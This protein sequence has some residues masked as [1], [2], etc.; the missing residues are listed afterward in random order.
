MAPATPCG[1]STLAKG[2]RQAGLGGLPP[3]RVAG[4]VG[5]EVCPGGFKFVADEAQ[6]E[7]PAPEGVLRVVRDRAGGACGL[8]VQGLGAYREAQLDVGLD[9]PGV[10]CAVEGAELDGVRRALRGEGGVEVEQVVAAVVVVVQGAHSPVSAAAATV[11]VPNLREAV[12]GGGLGLVDRLEESGRNRLAPLGPAFRGDAQGLC[13]EVF[14][15]IDQVD[16]PPQALR[17]VCPEADVDVDAAGAVNLGPGVPEVPDHRLHH[18]DVLPAAHRADHLRAGVGHRGIAF[19]RPMPPVRHRHLPVVEVGSDVPGGRS[20]EGRDGLGC[21]SAP[22]T[23]CFNLDAESLVFH[24]GSFARR[25][26]PPAA[27]G[28]LAPRRDT[29]ITLFAPNSNPTESTMFSPQIS[30]YYT[31]NGRRKNGFLN[32]ARTRTPSGIG[33]QSFWK[34]RGLCSFSAPDPQ[35]FCAAPPGSPAVPAPFC[36]PPPPGKGPW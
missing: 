21:A 15:G 32:I 4:Q 5:Q 31:K 14:L 26:F 25:L 36:P 16:Q 3:C 11:S 23:R 17:G 7:E 12:H 2:H 1:V 34:I 9:L 29:Y 33:C 13:Q 10:E 35:C 22:E 27:P 30:S 20:E 19:D 18:L 24:G 8:G 6:A 28:G